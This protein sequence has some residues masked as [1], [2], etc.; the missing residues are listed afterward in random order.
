ME[1]EKWNPWVSFLTLQECQDFIDKGLSNSVISKRY[2]ELIEYR[3]KKSIEREQEQ[4]RLSRE[5]GTLIERQKPSKKFQR[6][7]IEIFN[8]EEH[9]KKV[10]RGELL[11]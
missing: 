8:L 7:N 11:F 10:E 2:W 1:R 6:T 9:K 4:I 5:N 3:K